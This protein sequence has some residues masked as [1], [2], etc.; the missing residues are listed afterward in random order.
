MA[1]K[2]MFE[3][4]KPRPIFVMRCTPCEYRLQSSDYQVLKAAMWNH[5]VNHHIEYPEAVSDEE[6]GRIW[7]A[8]HAKNDPL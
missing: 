8:W 6:Q 5:Y 3:R 1:Y 2:S 4:N 7:H